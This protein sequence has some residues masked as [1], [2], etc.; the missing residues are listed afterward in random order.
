[1]IEGESE[2]APLAGNNEKNVEKLKSTLS[3]L[4]T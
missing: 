2:K 4:I 1:M 3:V